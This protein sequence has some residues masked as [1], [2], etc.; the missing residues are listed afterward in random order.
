MVGA[1]AAENCTFGDFQAEVEMRAVGPT[2]GG[3]YGLVFHRQFANS[4]SQYFVLINPESGTVRLV[5]WIDTE[6]A[7]LLPETPYPPVARG[8]GVNRLVVTT[9]GTLITIQIN[10]VEIVGRLNDPGPTIGVVGLR[11]D[12]GTG[13]ITVVFDNFV[14]RPV[15]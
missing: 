4:Y 12:S 15:Q 13:P 10:G 5:R 6:R 11:A 9:R 1:S 2:A 7:D 3:S 8:E 14:I